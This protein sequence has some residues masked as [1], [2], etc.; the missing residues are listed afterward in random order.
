MVVLK[1]ANPYHWYRMCM[2]ACMCHLPRLFFSDNNMVSSLW[3]IVF[4][5]GILSACA[6]E[7]SGAGESGGKNLY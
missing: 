4:S 5:L 1:R 2:H 6:E 3:F 7:S